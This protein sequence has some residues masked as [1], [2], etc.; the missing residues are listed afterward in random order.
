MSHLS[1]ARRVKCHEL[2]LDST[3]SADFIAGESGVFGNNSWRYGLTTGNHQQDISPHRPEKRGLA[4]LSHP[5]GE[6]A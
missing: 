4:R 6:G 2:A 5:N 1:P 3:R